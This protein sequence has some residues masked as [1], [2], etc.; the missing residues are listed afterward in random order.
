MPYIGNTIRAA[1]DY[2]LIDDISSSFNGSTTSFALQVAGSAPVPFPKSPQQ[3]L[4]SVNGVIQEPDPTGASGFNLVGTNI[5]FSSAPTNGHAFFGIIYATA[6]YLNAGGNFPSGSLGAPSITFI[7]DENS[8]LYRKSG[9]SVGFV[10]DATEIANFDSNGITISSG[11]LILGDSSGTN[12]DRIKLGASGDLEIYHNGT[13][14]EIINNTGDFVIQASAN[15]KLMLRAQTGESHLIG[16]H[17]AQVELYHNGSKKFETTSTGAHVVGTFEGDNFKVSNPGSDAVLIQNPAN[18]IIG[19]GANNQTNQV[20][21]TAD[22]H[23]G[24]PVDSKEL[25][26]GASDDLTITHNG[27]NSI[28]DNS[29]G[30]LRIQGDLVRIM[31]GAGTKVAIETNV[32]DNVELYFNNSKKAETVTG[33]FTVTGTCT[34]TAFAGDGSNLTGIAGT[35][36]NG[37]ANNRVITG[38]NTANTLDAEGNLTFTGDILSISSTTQGLGTSFTNTGNEYTQLKFSAARTAARNAIAIFEAKWNANHPV[39]SIYMQTGDDTTNKDD[40]IITFFTSASGGSQQSRMVIENDGNVTLSDGDLIIG[41]SGHGIDFS[42]TGNGGVTTPSELFD[43][44]EEGT[45]TPAGVNFTV[46][47]I[48]SAHYTKIGNVVFIQ[49]YVQAATGSGASPVSVSGLPYTVKGSNYYA[50]AACR[51]GGSASQG[52]DKVFQFNSGST[53]MTAFVADGNINEGMIS[54]QHLIMSGCYHVA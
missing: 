41:T 52:F 46:Q 43:D 51:I 19:F 32:D 28:I 3:V 40:G 45:W 22:G 18:G 12:D 49:M 54:G 33:G 21:I 35:T 29:T 36:I 8:G 7:G 4:V 24:I 25:R 47:T 1:D 48:Y 11:N 6:D 2:R 13:R 14:S 42:A 27:T 17:N 34:A 38:S 26:F 31:N 9:G 53:N 15:N 10:S 20:I 39:A 5:V 30:E 50:Y 23:L 44:Y 37:N 16:Y